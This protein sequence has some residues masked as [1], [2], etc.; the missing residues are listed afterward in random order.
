MSKILIIHHLEPMW[1]I[2]Y[3]D[4]GTGFDEL[5]EVFLEHLEEENYDKVILTRF[6]EW[7]CEPYIYGS[8]NHFISVTHPYAYG[9]ELDSCQP[10]TKH[11]K[12][13]N[14]Y[15]DECGTTWADGGSH[16]EIVLIDDWM[17][18]LKGHE[19]YISGA[20]DGECV[21]DLEFALEALEIPFQRLE[22]LIIG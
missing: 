13:E 4:F 8:L 14:L 1:E 15:V 18:D 3:N 19:V 12:F 21:E 7:E 16:S 2:G 17:F 10:L 6:E 20:F 5:L 9:W 22:K 11:P